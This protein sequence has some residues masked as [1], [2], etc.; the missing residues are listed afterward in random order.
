MTTLGALRREVAKAGYAEEAIIGDYVF[1][2]VL[3]PK[4]ID[5]QVALAA[6]TQ[7]PP[8]YRNAA[9]AAVVVTE[10]RPA[11]EIIA[12]HRALG[13]PLLFVIQGDDVTVW[14]VRSEGSS[15]SVARVQVDDLPAL[16]AEHKDDWSPLAIHRAK[17][18]G[19]VDRTYQLDFVDL[20]LLPVIEGEIHA[21]LDRLIE[22]TVAEA[23][24]AYQRRVGAGADERVLFRTTFRLLAAKV[25][26]D[27]GHD[28][29]QQ[30]NPD[31]IDSVVDAISAYYRLPRLPS[32]R[33]DL[34]RSV[35]GPAWSRLRRGISFRNISAD[36]LA[37][38]YENTL[39]TPETRKHF[40]THSTP[41]QV[42]EYVVS[43]LELWRH[44]PADIRV[45]EPFAGAGI[46]LVAAL[47]H[48]RDLLS[49]EWTD[50]ER[51][52]F[53]VKRIAGD[54]VDAFACEVATLSLIL[55]DYPN[56]NG[57]KI[58]ERDLMLNG[59]LLRRAS[60]ANVV[61]CNPPFEAFEEAEKARYPEM[62]ARSFTKG[63][64]A[65]NAVLDARPIALGF[66]LP[67]AFL[68]ERQFQSER[69]RVETLYSDIELVA[70]PERSFKVSGIESSLLIA[71][72]PRRETG[73]TRTSLRSS[74]VAQRD[75][76][77]FLRAGKVTQSRTEVRPYLEA[78]AGNLWVPEL[79]A[80]WRY[81]SDNRTLGSEVNIHRG[82]EWKGDQARATNPEPRPGY[83][84]GLH[85]ADVV[86]PFVLAPPTWLDLRPERLLY[87][88]AE[89]PWDRPKI[90]ANAVRISR[91]PWRLAAAVD[92]TGLVASQQLFGC[93][94]K[95]SGSHEELVALAAV[96]NGP[97]ANAF[98]SIHSP[99]KGI[100]LTTMRALPLPAQLP[101]DVA[102]LITAYAALASPKSFR[103]G[104]QTEG[105]AAA[106]LSEIDAA[107]L[108]AYDLPPRLERDLLEFFRGA[109]R[110]TV[111][112]WRYWLPEDFRP[113]LPLHEYLSSTYAKAARPWPLEVFEPL[114]PEEASV[115][116]QYLD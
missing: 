82:I 1:S 109:D 85:S 90:I 3:A 21:K 16:F 105:E 53:L 93:W 50:R 91:G 96:L 15:R 17:S 99:A 7:T 37:F 19:A 98:V 11:A 31:N 116:R 77:D 88:A 100:R 108:R 42:A 94:L 111:H 5:R 106:L 67:R 29:A 49:A 40:G 72:S 9:L 54:E 22:E 27:R 20:G 10:H 83:K 58:S 41:R 35:F 25:L 62:V 114:P 92:D 97:V 107:V 32:E 112:P 12:E 44:N 26:Q 2:D 36:D 24:R 4:P 95:E 34:Q 71:R 47:R 56:A 45:Y 23:L 89:L 70:L 46:F 104:H 78:V 101:L 75:R 113:T 81:L 59:T 110:P 76:V 65:L 14:Q 57:W 79:N 66:V 6:F 103:L 80:V 74:V 68:D 28:L 43:R 39:I 52:D 8:S 48:L 84:P 87:K 69:Q 38:V 30:W 64:A 51:H 115:L 33:L 60:T 18:I 73:A 55:A 86:K 13:A 63:A 61:L 102:P